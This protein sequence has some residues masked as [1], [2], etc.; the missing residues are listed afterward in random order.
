MARRSAFGV[1][2]V[3]NNRARLVIDR[4]SPGARKVV[5]ILAVFAITRL[6]VWWLYDPGVGRGD[7]TQY[8]RIAESIATH[9]A[10]G[11]LDP[12]YR[13]ERVPGFYPYFHGHKSLPD[14]QFNPIFWDPLYPLFLAI[15]SFV[16]GPSPAAVRALQLLISAAT[17]LLGI[18]IV[19]EL[20]PRNP[21]ASKTF[22]WLFVAF[23]PFAGYVT[24]LL[25]ETLDAFFLTLMIWLMIRLGAD[26]LRHS[27]SLG[28]LLGCYVSLKSYWFQL[29]PLLM[30]FAWW[31][32]ARTAPAPVT[33]TRQLLHAVLVVSGCALLLTPTFV[34]NHNIGDVSFTV[35]TKSSWNFW[36][37]NNNFLVENHNWRA[38]GLKIRSW[39]K[40]YY[41][42]G[43]VD[44]V[45]RLLEGVYYDP[46]QPV[47]PPCDVPLPEL[48]ACERDR[49][50]AFFIEDPLR[51]IRRALEKNL[52]LWSPNSYV[53]NRAPP[54]NW[55]WN[56]NLRIEL[57]T[58][59]RYALQIWGI[60]AY[61]LVMFASFIGFASQAQ[62][63]RDQ[64]TRA[65]VALCIGCLI[66]IVVAVGH[67]LTRFRLPYMVPLAMYAALG[68]SVAR[69][70]F[71]EPEGRTRRL[72]VAGG[73]SLLMLTV[74]F[75]RLPALLAP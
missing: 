23:L 7:E 1:F 50:V 55:A 57:P 67:G 47:R 22:G 12:G 59:V 27:F 71:L 61:L 35:S 72:L 32:R 3:H 70:T 43:N 63:P 17:L 75:L 8:L 66:F 33:T 37:D 56:Q 29:L 19:R 15:S 39:L 42:S 14:G 34:R 28:L 16:F 49:A 11:Y 41:E 38:P 25:G 18:S 58:V 5:A 24:K 20:F 40:P 48:T 54:G 62:S 30:A 69:R 65:L 73:L 6:V 9:G 45:S 64:V 13:L 10:S 52:N 2:G 46:S 53:F 36:K 31:A 26:R 68:L 4:S 51:F 60:A 21:Q 44:Q 74:V